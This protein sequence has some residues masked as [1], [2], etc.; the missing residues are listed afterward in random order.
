MIKI[1]NILL[2]SSVLVLL[3]PSGCS[4]DFLRQ[5]KVD[6]ISEESL[7]NKESD[8]LAIVSSVYDIFHNNVSGIGCCNDYVIK[9]L[10]YQ[11][12]FLSQDIRNVGADVFYTTYEVPATFQPLYILWA[13]SYAGIA[14]SNAAIT[15]LANMLEEGIITEELANRL[16]GE[17]YF[18]RGL[19]YTFLASS[20]GGVPL[21]IEE[22]KA[23]DDFRRP[24]NTEAETFEQI[25]KDM[26][27]AAE[28]L[29]WTYSAEN[30]GRATK[31][32]AL[33]YL[34]EAQ[35]WLRK[36]DEAV[37]TFETIVNEGPYQL[38]AAY[39]N[40]H[41][42]DNE[43][44][45]ESI[46]E[47]QYGESPNYSW[48]T[49]DQTQALTSF[50]MPAEV[51]GCGCAKVTQELYDSFEEGDERRVATVIG[52]GEEHPSEN[53]DIA[54]Y[55]RV[56]ENYDS[57][58]TLGTVENPWI[59]QG[60]SGY[61]LTKLWRSAQASGWGG[62]NIF[63]PQNLIVMRYGQVL[64]DLAEARAKNGNTDGAL[65]M[66]N[67]IRGRAGLEPVSM[68]DGEVMD[69]ILS[70]YRHELAGEFSLW[71]ILRRSGKA[72]EYVANKYGID[73]PAGKELL[74]IPQPEIDVNPNLMQN[75]G[76]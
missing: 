7:F 22:L 65:E 10:W 47:L 15:Q 2:I 9:G 72:R 33:A 39:F 50:I 5:E 51:G 63:I 35:M 28:A 37:T 14:R 16:T 36:Y 75:P 34:G 11:A 57:I 4:D 54:D 26:K 45:V 73:I 38:E 52:P 3:L 48:G 76:Y 20:F 29:P 64:L 70:E 61:A 67:Q 41:E 42:P 18:L 56:Q 30:M 53:I 43:N 24:R 12:N 71:W 27:A 49:I 13:D 60:G 6:G 19:L 40:I 62:D 69:L 74:P 44:G 31:G 68:A 58:N 21:I 59:T 23:S 25:E 32:A 46:F 66:V 55:P 1:K 17:V 8:A